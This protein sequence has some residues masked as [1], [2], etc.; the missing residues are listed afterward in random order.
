MPDHSDF[1]GELP[2]V[3]A[4][5]GLT[6]LREPAPVL[7]GTL[8]WNFRVETSA[9][10]AFVRR[11]RDNLETERIAGEH[12]L[13]A[14]VAGRGIPAPVPFHAADGASIIELGP[15]RWAIF[16]WAPG[17]TLQR[18]KLSPS[19]ARALGSLHGRLQATL[20]GHPAS[21]GASMQLAWDKAESLAALE[22]IA[23]KARETG[24]AGWLQRGLQ[25]QHTMLDALEVPPPAFYSSLPVQLLHGD[26]HDQQVLWEGERVTALVDWEIWHADP[27]IW[28]V[29]RSL[30]F[31]LMLESPLLEEYL[32]GY[33]AHVQLGEAE[34]SL[35]LRLWWQSRLVGLWV[36]AAYF[37]QG[38]ERV[39]AFFPATVAELDRI[40][41]DR[42]R[43]AIE[44]RFIRAACG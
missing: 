19:Q 41:D 15:A 2:A 27:R 20:A 44:T 5:Y 17:A 11:Y 28:E 30:A 31:S 23:L 26:F 16:P 36:W 25:R 7:G 10:P 35:G 34:C 38:N 37:L 14:W 43:E 6:A 29:V 13:T 21:A 1:A 32:G 3:L 24:A 9:G 33:R 4:A 8:N 39:A 22:L 40:A 18:G 42:W 12:Q